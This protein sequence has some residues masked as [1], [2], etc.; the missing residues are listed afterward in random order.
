MRSFKSCFIAMMCLVANTTA[1]FD[2]RKVSITEPITIF[3]SDTTDNKI[4][5]TGITVS[6]PFDTLS[7]GAQ[8]TNK[9]VQITVAVQPSNATNHAFTFQITNHGAA[10]LNNGA[11]TAKAAGVDTV[12]VTSTSNPN[13]KGFSVITVVANSC[14]PVTS[15]SIVLVPDHGNGAKGTTT[16]VTAVVTAPA[17]VN[18]SVIWYSTDPS[19]VAVAQKDGDSITLNGQVILNNVKGGTLY[20]VRA[21]RAGDPTVS[22]CA[23]SVADPTVRACGVWFGTP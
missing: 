12:F 20:F 6:P 2:N 4:P 23:Q 9:S 15:I 1:C 5:I 13:I 11:V 7:V 21:Q 3:T 16:Q 14:V 22:I 8:C 19:Q 18:K 10:T 17:G